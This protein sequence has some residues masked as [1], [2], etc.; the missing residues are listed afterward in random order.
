MTVD[1]LSRLPLFMQKYDELVKLTDSQNPEFKLLWNA[2]DQARR[3]VFIYTAGEEGL[4]RFERMLNITPDPG[5][6]IETRRNKVLM[7]WSNNQPFTL[8]FLIELL[9]VMTDDRFEIY[10]NFDMYEMEIILLDMNYDF[11]TEL[12]FIK[13]T[14]IPANIYLRIMNRINYQSQNNIGVGTALVRVIE[15]N[16]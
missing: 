15:I 7:R 13:Q 8:R 12:E 5:E 9:K 14:I 16:I 1:L 2:E 10:T 4:R 6:S 3:D 11:F